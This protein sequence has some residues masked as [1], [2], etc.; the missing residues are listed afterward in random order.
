MLAFLRAVL[1]VSIVFA[2]LVEGAP[3]GAQQGRRIALVIGNSAYDAKG[4]LSLPSSHGNADEIA[5]ALERANFEVV[6]RY[7]V[8]WAQFDGSLSDF[9]KAAATAS[10]AVFYYSGHVLHVADRT[11]LMPINA[12][13]QPPERRL[14]NHRSGGGC[15]SSN[16]G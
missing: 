4:P 7:D 15:Y 12:T 6:R 10:V 14:P 9:E 16:H 1:T 3:A 5:N 13:L 8:D 2:F 11:Y